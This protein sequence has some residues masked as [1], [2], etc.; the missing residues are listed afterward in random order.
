[1]WVV[2]CEGTAGNDMTGAA[3][4]GAGQGTAGVSAAGTGGTGVM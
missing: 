4:T 2:A 1:M 3:G